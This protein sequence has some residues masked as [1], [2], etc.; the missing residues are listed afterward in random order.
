MEAEYPRLKG[1]R[2]MLFLSRIHPK[3]GLAHLFKAWQQLASE[4]NE[5]ILLVAGNDQLGHEQEMR[6][7]AI[8]LGLGNAVVFLG[9]LYGEAKKKMM[10][11][12]DA[13][14]LPSFSEGFSMAVL[15]AAACGLPVMLTPQCN[16]PELAAAG[17]A[18]EVQPEAASCEVGLRQMFSFSNA[19]RKRMGARG[20]KLIR[21]D[22]TWPAIAARMAAVYAWLLR[23]G[24]KPDCVSLN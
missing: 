8:G 9:P 14:V 20:Q 11:G 6:S 19:E 17:G 4:F 10:A 3:K 12:S 2:R 24:P 18:V 5:W 15:E 23:Q 16:F 1:K 13:F 7:L 21:R 22:Y